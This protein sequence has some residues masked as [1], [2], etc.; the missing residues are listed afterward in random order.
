MVTEL[1]VVLV[2]KQIGLPLHGRPILLITRMITDGIGLHL[3]LLPLL[4]ALD[5]VLKITSAYWQR[6]KNALYLSL[7]EQP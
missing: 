1:R 3:V 2:M 6:Q 7:N 5:V 4:I